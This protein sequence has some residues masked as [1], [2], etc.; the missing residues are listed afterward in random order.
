MMTKD[1][2]YPWT[3]NHEWND[4]WVTKSVRRFPEWGKTFDRNNL[5]INQVRLLFGEVPSKLDD[6]YIRFSIR[7]GRSY[8]IFHRNVAWKEV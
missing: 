2:V 5:M 7:T 4:E 8:E 3:K 6:F 1:A